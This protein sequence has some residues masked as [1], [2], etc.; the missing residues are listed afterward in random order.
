MVSSVDTEVLEEL[1]TDGANENISSWFM[2]V[3]ETFVTWKLGP[4]NLSNLLC[5]GESNGST[6]FG[7]LCY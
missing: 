4:E 6:T 7:R 3:D 5:K 1:A 2:Y